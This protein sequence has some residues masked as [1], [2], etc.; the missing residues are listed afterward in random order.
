LTIWE[1]VEFRRKLEGEVN[2]R[3]RDAA[4]RF[5]RPPR[6]AGLDL[7]GRRFGRLKVVRSAGFI[8][9]TGGTRRL[10]RAKCDCGTVITVPTNSLQSGNTESCSCRKRDLTIKK[11]LARAV[12]NHTAKRVL[13]PTWISWQAMRQRCLNKNTRSYPQYGGA[14]VTICKRW[15]KFLNFLHDL[16]PRPKNKTLGRRSDMGNYTPANCSWET[17]AQQER[18]RRRKKEGQ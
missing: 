3:L 15:D 17:R 4:G 8:A 9:I 12:H 10:W 13:S 14:G 6:R 7:T 16:G 5:T 18:E 11:N 1:G 2:E